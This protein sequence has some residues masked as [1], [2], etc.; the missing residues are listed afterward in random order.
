MSEETRKP[1]DA[2]IEGGE[3]FIYSKEWVFNQWVWT[4]HHITP[5]RFKEIAEQYRLIAEK[6]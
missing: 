2:E 4:R 3:V 6:L 1:F 5:E